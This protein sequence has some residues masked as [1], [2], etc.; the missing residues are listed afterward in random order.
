MRELT[1]QLNDIV[2]LETVLCQCKETEGEGGIAYKGSI[3]YELSAPGAS[4]DDD[5]FDPTNYGGNDIATASSVG[6]LC[7][8]ADN[9]DVDVR[10][11]PSVE[12][13]PCVPP[14]P[15]GH[16]VERES[17]NGHSM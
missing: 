12:E 14:M 7:V 1:T 9:E 3:C 11:M 5:D 13:H 4:C 6:G 10:D 17:E 2:S 15:L 16:D 8:C